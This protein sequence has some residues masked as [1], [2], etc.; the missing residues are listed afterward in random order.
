M[1]E[2]APDRTHQRDANLFAL[3]VLTARIPA[4]HLGVEARFTF[5]KRSSSQG[6]ARVPSALRVNPCIA[7]SSLHRALLSPPQRIQSIVRPMVVDRRLHHTEQM[8][9]WR[10]FRPLFVDTQ[11]AANRAK[12]RQHHFATRLDQMPQATRPTPA[13]TTSPAP[14]IPAQTARRTRLTRRE[15]LAT[16]PT[17]GLWPGG[18]KF[19]ESRQF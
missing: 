19:S 16:A 8:L 1:P 10:L 15:V 9:E 7:R 12:P 11:V 17:A 6:R 5:E 3:A 2:L 4:R 14:N 18:Q 13:A